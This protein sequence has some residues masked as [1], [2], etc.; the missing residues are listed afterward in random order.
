MA[1]EAEDFVSALQKQSDNLVKF[2]RME[3]C[4][5]GFD[6]RTTDGTEHAKAKKMAYEMA[7]EMLKS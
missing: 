7:V 5:H 4:T 2:K 3:G 6:K 1:S